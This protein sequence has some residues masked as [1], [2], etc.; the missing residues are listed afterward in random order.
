MI[1][2]ESDENTFKE[3]AG[4]YALNVYTGQWLLHTKPP[5]SRHIS[6]PSVFVVQGAPDLG[7]NVM[8]FQQALLTVYSKSYSCTLQIYKFVVV[9]KEK[10]KIMFDTRTV[11]KYKTNC[12]YCMCANAMQLDVQIGLLGYPTFIERQNTKWNYQ[13]TEWDSTREME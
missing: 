5:G 6:S 2:S 10:Q 8:N 7:R 12:I 1:F 11:R 4:N 3:V 9:A 13:S